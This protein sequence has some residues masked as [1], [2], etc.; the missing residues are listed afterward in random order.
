MFLETVLLQHQLSVS[1][2]KSMDH[3]G[4]H[5]STRAICAAGLG[6][7][8]RLYITALLM[9]SP[10]LAR[11]ALVLRE[12]CLHIAPGSRLGDWRWT[13]AAVFRSGAQRYLAYN[14]E[15]RLTTRARVQWL[16]MYMRW[17]AARAP[18]RSCASLPGF[19]PPRTLYN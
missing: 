10:A 15:V 19:L 4:G 7:I 18:R 2:G 5:V 16:C 13:E 8:L 9:L 14:D 6:I 1:A 11:E 3:Q 12:G 17:R